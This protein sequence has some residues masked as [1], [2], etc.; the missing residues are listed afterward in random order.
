MAIISLYINTIISPPFWSMKSHRLISSEWPSACTCPCTPPIIARRP[1]SSAPPSNLV[2]FPIIELNSKLLF[3]EMILSLLELLLLYDPL[4]LSL[5]LLATCVELI[6]CTTLKVLRGN[7]NV[8]VN[9]FRP[10]LYTGSENIMAV[11]NCLS[12]ILSAS[13]TVEYKNNV[14]ALNIK[15]VL[16]KSPDGCQTVRPTRRQTNK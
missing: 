11:F 10:D 9:C 15:N 1:L 6:P 16:K 14:F 12:A 2:L 7:S 8:L 3:R 4:L 13:L 5:L